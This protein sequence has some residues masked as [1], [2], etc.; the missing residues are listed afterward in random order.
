MSESARLIRDWQ[1]IVAQADLKPETIN[2]IA[3]VC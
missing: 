3:Q 1:C 2:Q